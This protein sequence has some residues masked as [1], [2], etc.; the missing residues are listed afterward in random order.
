MAKKQRWIPNQ[1]FFMEVEGDTRVVLCGCRG[2]CTYTEE[3]VALR[4]PF[5]VV[6]VYG[7]GLEMGC[8]TA[9]GATITGRLQR[10]E[11]SQ[12]ESLW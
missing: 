11:F 6:A 7:Q 1:G 8:M 9:E 10:I 4:T 3:C 5:G 12:E 2:I